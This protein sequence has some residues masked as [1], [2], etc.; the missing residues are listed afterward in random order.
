MALS[1]PLKGGCA[2]GKIRYEANVAPLFG[3]LCCCRACQR[4]TGT[5]YNAVVGVPAA[6]LQ[7]TQGEPK[8]YDTAADSGG[9]LRRAFCADCGSALFN[10]P[11]NAPIASIA[12]GSLDDPSGYEPG[13]VVFAENAHAWVALPEGITK[14]PK[15]P[16]R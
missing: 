13:V 9:T 12:V 4:A 5:A 3:G 10:R 8:Y 7:V 15:M 16:P 6:A 14:F 2:C 1:A 11:S